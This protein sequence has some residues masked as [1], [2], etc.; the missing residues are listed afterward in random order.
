MQSMIPAAE[1]YNLRGGGDERTK[2]R[3]GEEKFLCFSF[4]FLSFC[5]YIL[6]FWPCGFEIFINP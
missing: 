2:K 6:L 1:R 5:F 4:S 3:S